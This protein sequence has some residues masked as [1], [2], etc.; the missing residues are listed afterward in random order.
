M[1]GGINVGGAYIGG[2][3]KGEDPTNA[4]IGAGVGAAAGSGAGKVVTDKLKPIVTDKTADTLGALGG[5]F[6][7]ENAGAA[8]QDQ[9]SAHE[10]SGDKK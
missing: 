8:V 7:S 1:T 4:M 10:K 9:L 2:T 5:A 3:I 6:V